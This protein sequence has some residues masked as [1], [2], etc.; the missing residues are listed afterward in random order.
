MMNSDQLDLN[1][2]NKDFEFLDG[3]DQS[4]AFLFR[5]SVVAFA[6]T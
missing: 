4:E 5:G 2:P 1:S 3:P 6:W